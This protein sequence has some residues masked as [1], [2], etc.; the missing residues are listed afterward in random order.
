MSGH[1]H[2]KQDEDIMITESGHQ[3]QRIYQGIRMVIGISRS[4]YKAIR[5]QDIRV[6]GC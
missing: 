4:G 2:I 3:Y 6:S 5:D 1:Y